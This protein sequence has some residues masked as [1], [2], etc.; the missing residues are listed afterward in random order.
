MIY[1][2][3]SV[4][5]A[6]FSKLGED[7][8]RVEGAGADFLHLDVMDGVFVPN[9]SFGPAVIASLRRSRLLFD[10]HLMI[11]KPEKMIDEFI[12]AGADMI[13]FHFE[14]CDSPEPLI[15][16]IKEMS[17][18]AS[19]AISPSTPVDVLLPFLPL[20]DMVLIMTVEPGFGGQKLIPA[21]VDKVR[22]LRRIIDENGYSCDIEV[23]GG[24]SAGNVGLLTSAGANVIVAGSAIFGAPSARRAIVN[25][26]TAAAAAVY[27]K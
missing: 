21:T 24:I 9:I 22:T 10:V 5:A 17:V 18:R 25:M 14:A 15:R 13:T 16:H 11:T 19:M 2:S 27:K 3:P 7:V 1:I 6:D 20:L 23:D 4:L 12:K 8:S 26:R